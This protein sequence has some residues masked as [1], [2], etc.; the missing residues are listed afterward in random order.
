MW[1]PISEYGGTII[2]RY[3]INI[4]HRLRIAVSKTFGT[5]ETKEEVRIGYSEVHFHPEYSDEGRGAVRHD[6]SMCI[7]Y[8]FHGW[9]I[10]SRDIAFL[11]LA[12]PYV[13]SHILCTQLVICLL[14]HFIHIWYLEWPC[15]EDAHIIRQTTRCAHKM[16][17]RTYVQTNMKKT[18]T[19]R[20][21]QP[22]VKSV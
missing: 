14:S 3:P 13:R 8:R 18:M 19:P 9:L 11:M 5:L 16:C 15:S 10:F 4:M 12:W 21:N 2:I 17:V 7:L 1:Y 20:K 22:S 6:R